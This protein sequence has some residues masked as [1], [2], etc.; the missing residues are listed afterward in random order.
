[1]HMRNH[2]DSKFT[3]SALALITCKKKEGKGDEP[4]VISR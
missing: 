2:Q 1:M 3:L 4:G